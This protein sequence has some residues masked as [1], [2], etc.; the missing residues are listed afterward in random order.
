MTASR[1]AI[2]WRAARPG[3]AVG[4]SATLSGARLLF[5][6]ARTVPGR[7]RLRVTGALGPFATEAAHVAL[8]WA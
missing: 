8:T 5:V 7:G 2:S 4:L 1:P 3:V 6:E